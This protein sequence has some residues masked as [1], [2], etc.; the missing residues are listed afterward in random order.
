MI[1]VM[2]E[3]VATKTFSFLQSI[4]HYYWLLVTGFGS[5]VI[6][7][8]QTKRGLLYKWTVVCLPVALISTQTVCHLAAKQKALISLCGSAIQNYQFMWLCV[9]T[10]FSL[11]KLNQQC[12]KVGLRLLQKSH[13]ETD[14]YGDICCCW[15]LPN[16]LFACQFVHEGAAV[17]CVSVS[18]YIICSTA[19]ASNTL[20]SSVRVVSPRCAKWPLP[21][22]CC[23][24]TYLCSQNR[25]ANIVC[26]AG[27]EGGGDD[28][29]GC[30]WG[31]PRRR[32]AGL[33]L[34]PSAADY[35]PGGFCTDAQRLWWDHTLTHT[36]THSW[37]YL[38]S[39]LL[40]IHCPKDSARGDFIFI[41]KV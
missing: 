4:L 40:W 25:T 33:G 10:V 16:Q 17:C 19:C 7:A 32:C 29:G 34:H 39:A 26:A 36:H 1:N 23:D 22:A 5:S 18:C 41:S 6:T 27:P 37:S 35:P 9:L 31:R 38:Y 15:L 2:Q 21:P 8:G 28:K 14:V 30:F 11:E 12:F 24:K 3:C 13:D 20:E